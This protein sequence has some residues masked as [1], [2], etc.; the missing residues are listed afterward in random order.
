VQVVVLPSWN[1]CKLLFSLG[2]SQGII[3]VSPIFSGLEGQ[4][5]VFIREWNE[6]GGGKRELEGGGYLRATKSIASARPLPMHPVLKAAL[7]E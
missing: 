4:S 6:R 3:N 5:W 2:P 7:L 1:E